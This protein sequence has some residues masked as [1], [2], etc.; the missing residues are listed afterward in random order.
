MFEFLQVLK[1]YSV[2]FYIL[3]IYYYIFCVTSRHISCLV[4]C[5]GVLSVIKTTESCSFTADV[6]LGVHDCGYQIVDQVFILMFAY[7]KILLTDYKPVD[8]V[9]HYILTSVS[10]LL[11]F[12]MYLCSTMSKCS[13]FP[14]SPS[15]SKSLFLCSSFSFF[16]FFVCFVSSWD[17][18]HKMVWIRRWLQCYGDGVTWPLLRGLV[19]LLFTP[20]Y[21]KDCTSP[22]GPACKFSFYFLPN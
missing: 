5:F 9:F 3:V 18:H 11:C 8:I 12:S 17:P 15:P 14:I 4:D 20:L 13:L 19:Q 22:S 1:R 6:I 2:F 16:I 21:L 7:P 10:L